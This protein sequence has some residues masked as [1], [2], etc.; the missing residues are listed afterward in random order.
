MSEWP[1]QAHGKG[2]KHGMMLSQVPEAMPDRPLPYMF[3]QRYGGGGRP[4][5]V[6]IGPEMVRKLYELVER[7]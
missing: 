2:K 7:R 4:I 1:P 5:G 6:I 3:E